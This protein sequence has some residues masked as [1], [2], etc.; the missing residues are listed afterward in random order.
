ME[1]SRALGPSIQATD[2]GAVGTNFATKWPPWDGGAMGLPDSAKDT[3]AETH[4]GLRRL[5]EAQVRVKPHPQPVPTT[6]ANTIS[7]KHHTGHSANGASQNG[8]K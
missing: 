2:A 1:H 5:S 6:H 3:A 4:P 8:I 7:L